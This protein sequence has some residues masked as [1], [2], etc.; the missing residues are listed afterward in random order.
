[1]VTVFRV[2][3]DY[4]SLIEQIF[5]I[6]NLPCEVVSVCVNVCVWL[7]KDAQEEILREG[8]VKGEGR[9]SPSM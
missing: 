9:E 7:R 5:K 3:V 2:S 4:Q 6:F 8:K 1:M